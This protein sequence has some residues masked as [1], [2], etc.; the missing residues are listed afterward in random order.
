MT[1]IDSVR[2]LL[3][4]LP[5]A[6]PAVVGSNNSAQQNELTPAKLGAGATPLRARNSQQQQ[7][8]QQQ[9]QQQLFFGTPEKFSGGNS[10]SANDKQLR[11][12]EEFWRDLHQFH[13]RRG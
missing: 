13:E 9:V 5:A 4:S 7:L 8:Q 2:V 3:Q 12:P 1:S 6:S 10:A 11:A